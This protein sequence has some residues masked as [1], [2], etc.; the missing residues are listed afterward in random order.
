VPAASSK[1]QTRRKYKPNHWQ[2]GLSPHSA[3][4]ITGRKK[5]QHKEETK[6]DP[7]VKNKTN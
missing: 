2:R 7:P 5:I 4:P 3:L 6:N 1:H